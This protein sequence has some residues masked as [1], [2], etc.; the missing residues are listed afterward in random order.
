MKWRSWRV[1]YRGVLPDAYLDRL[2]IDP[3][4][5]YWIG[6]GTMAPSRRHRVLV[7]GRPGT[8]VGMV[9]L[10]PTRDDGLDPDAVSEIV[11]LY[12]EP[13]VRRRALGRRLLD[14]AV[15]E[16]HGLGIRDLRLWVAEQN[17]AARA[18]YGSRGWRPDGATQTVRPRGF[19]IGDGG[20]A[21]LPPRPC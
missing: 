15:D 10:R 17:V 8:V 20:G 4:V 12:L 1:A 21:P 2:E 19:G 3:P 7:A 14:A 16:A 9:D 6:V 18:F 11:M 5:G 13:L